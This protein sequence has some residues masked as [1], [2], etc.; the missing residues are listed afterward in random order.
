VAPRGDCS[1]SASQTS[2][3]VLRDA[4]NDHKDVLRWK[5]SRG[6]NVS[7]GA[8]GDLVGGSTGMRVCVYDASAATQPLVGL[9]VPAAGTCGKK[10]CWKATRSGGYRYKN[11]A[12]TATGVTGVKLRGS[13]AGG[14][15]VVVKCRGANLP[16]PALGATPPVVVQLVTGDG[17]GET[18]WQAVFASVLPNDA[19]VVKAHQP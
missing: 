18:C 13:E 12:G 10:P 1:A 15:Q 9:V 19:T 17:I 7:I 6:G 11:R 16:M 2:M 5:L 3:L 14:V 4:A 8:F